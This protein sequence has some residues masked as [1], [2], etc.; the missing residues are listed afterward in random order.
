MGSVTAA[1][2]RRLR[3]ATVTFAV[4]VLV[5]NGDH[6]RRG[7]DAVSWD[8]FTLGTLGIVLEVCVVAIVLMGHRWGP[9]AAAA[10]GS[11][12]A[13]GYVAVHVLPDRPWLSDSLTTGE[14]ITWF[15]WVAVIG[16]VAAATGLA[17]AGWAV[18]RR[19]GGLASAAGGAPP[20]GSFRHPVTAAM[21]L[22]NLAILAGSVATL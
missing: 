2:D 20:S 15:S 11:A 9:L 8:V 14:D 22:G 3:L 13:A 5:H 4:A 17:T 18:L 1:D 19:R 12:L 6:L 16:L 10:I 21:V 7:G